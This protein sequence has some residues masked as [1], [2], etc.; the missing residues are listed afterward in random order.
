MLPQLERCWCLVLCKNDIWSKSFRKSDDPSRAYDFFLQIVNSESNTNGSSS[1]VRD[2]NN[3]AIYRSES[4]TQD[5]SHPHHFFVQETCHETLA[6]GAF[7]SLSWVPLGFR[8]KERKTGKVGRWRGGGV[9]GGWREKH[10]PKYLNPLSFLLSQQTLTDSSGSHPP[11]P[12]PPLLSLLSTS[13]I[14]RPRQSFVFID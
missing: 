7:S 13:P 11:T 9:G 2:N 5:A 14:S 10:E 4:S 12:F 8:D 3:N 6:L 1:A